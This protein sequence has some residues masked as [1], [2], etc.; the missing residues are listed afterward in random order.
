[1]LNIEE[2]G[3][4]EESYKM[5]FHY[6][7]R[8]EHKEM[9]CMDWY[10]GPLEFRD[11]METCELFIHNYY[12]SGPDEWMHVWLLGLPVDYNYDDGKKYV[13]IIKLRGPMDVFISGWGDDFFYVGTLTP[14]E[15]L[16]TRYNKDKFK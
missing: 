16:D 10:D 11:L 6:P 1:M 13:D 15:V 4:H 9:W 12:R 8:I 5:I 7:D 3:G 14:E 2:L